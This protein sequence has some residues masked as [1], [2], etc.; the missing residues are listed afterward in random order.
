[1]TATDAEIAQAFRECAEGQHPSTDFGMMAKHIERRARELDA[2]KGGEG[3]NTGHGHVW[4]RPDGVKA[5]CG[6]PGLCAACSIDAARY[7]ATP[8]A[9]AAEAVERVARGLATFDAERHGAC[10]DTN[11][12][13]N[14][15]YYT[16]LARA[17]IAAMQAGE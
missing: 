10:P 2:E 3:G 13:M 1:M 4:P 7:R 5:R 12:G 17:A 9:Q 11:L 6:G 14:E 15:A 8:P 16:S